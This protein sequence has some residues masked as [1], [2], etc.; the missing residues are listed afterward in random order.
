MAETSR[1]TRML[2]A[3]IAVVVVGV[4]IAGGLVWRDDILRTG[5]DPKEPFQ[6]YD[7]PPAPNYAEREAW[8]LLPESPQTWADD[9]PVADVFFIGP[10]LYD[11]G[12][13]WNAPIDDARS[14]AFFRRTIGPNYVGPFVRVGRLFAP[15]YRQAS[16]YSM[17]TLRDDA[18]EARRFAYGDV[19]RAFRHYISL[20]NHGRPFLIVG[21]EQGGTLAAR[22]LAEEV[23]SDPD[24]RSRLVAAYL[25]QTAVPAAAPPI[26][27]CTT[28]T[29]PGCLAAWMSAYEGDRERAQELRDRSLVWTQDGAL[30]N[31]SGLAACYNPILGQVSDAVAPARLARGATNATG[32]EWGA[33]PA[34][35]SR[36]VGAHC[37]N[38]VLRVSRPRSAAFRPIGSWADR[39]KMPGYNLFYGDLEANAEARLNTLMADPNF[40]R[41]AR[42][43]PEGAEVGAAPVHRID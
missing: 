39:Q 13:H 2:F 7:P 40:P 3:A 8:S 26:P 19:R 41:A 15:Q 21:V 6:T 36:Q 18:R 23:A 33:R 28:P 11:G 42:Q 4:L 16:L 29:E 31:L 10:T 1:R 25:I 9:D 43:I 32:L 20:Y 38:S 5:L 17:L 24:I 30:I 37:E 35:Q 34:L 14:E 27:L 12:R 22:L